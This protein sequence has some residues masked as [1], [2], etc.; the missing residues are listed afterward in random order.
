MDDLVDAYQKVYPVLRNHAMGFLSANYLRNLIKVGNID[1]EGQIADDTIAD[2]SIH[3][4]I[5]GKENGSSSLTRFQR[6]ILLI[7]K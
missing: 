6:L 3:I 1:F 5:E 2:D 7:K 4:I